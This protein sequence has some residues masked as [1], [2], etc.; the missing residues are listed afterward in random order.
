[1][2]KKSKLQISVSFLFCLLFSCIPSIGSAEE[3]LFGGLGEIFIEGIE[4]TKKQFGNLN[5]GSPESSEKPQEGV[6]QPDS[7][8]TSSEPQ[9]KPSPTASEESGKQSE[10]AEPEL[11]FDPMDFVVMN[12]NQLQL[13]GF[14]KSCG[15]FAGLSV[16]GEVVLDKNASVESALDR[17][18]T[19]ARFLHL[20]ELVI[21]L[22]ISAGAEWPKDVNREIP[23]GDWKHLI[24]GVFEQGALQ[25]RLLSLNKLHADY[26]QAS[27]FRKVPELNTIPRYTLYN[28]SEMEVQNY[29]KKTLGPNFNPEYKIV[30]HWLLR[31]YPDFEP[32][33]EIFMSNLDGEPTEIF[34]SIVKAVYS[35]AENQEGLKKIEEDISI[36]HHN[37]LSA[38]KD[39][40]ET[41]WQ[42]RL[43]KEQQLKKSSSAEPKAQ[44][45]QPHELSQE[46]K[47]MSEELAEFKK[48][49]NT[50]QVIYE[51]RVREYE[52]ALEKL[53]AEVNIIKQGQR[54]LTKEEQ[55][56]AQNIQHTVEGTEKLMCGSEVET[57]IAGKHLVEGF[58]T[59]KNDLAA[60]A[61]TGPVGLERMR[62]I[63]LN[64]IALPWNVKTISTELGL[65][66]KR[67]AIYDGLFENRVKKGC[68]FL[69]IACKISGGEKPP[70]GEI[71]ESGK[72]EVNPGEKMVE[73]EN[74]R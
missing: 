10:Q 12:P 23:I 37:K 55:A 68:G 50:Q 41:L 19:A 53:N 56:L 65:L 57:I 36:A 44:K 22:P 25:G 30:F 38:R 67:I 70:A 71:V 59:L 66:D 48:E 13:P 46:E 29:G 28:P 51:T 42:I 11:P 14:P 31:H 4:K 2:K 6:S 17:I 74:A 54:K 63:V 7:N 27:L 3:S 33:S 45:I 39:V 58:P 9:E 8:K 62:N 5:L 64:L 49:F 26:V 1:M 47:L 18:N 15:W 24:S 52:S 43:I 40:E 73:A 34:P 16:L 21:H 60:L 72:K 20:S 35:I 69:D 32:K 61:V